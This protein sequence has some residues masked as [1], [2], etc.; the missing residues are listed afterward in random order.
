MILTFPG[1]KGF[2]LIEVLVALMVLT[3]GLLAVAAM[4]AR[5]VRGNAQ[6]VQMT[7]AV[8]CAEDAMEKLL[9]RPYHHADLQD[10]VNPGVIAM[11]CTDHVGTPS[12]AAD[13][14]PTIQGSC[15]VFWNIVDNH[16]VRSCKSIRVLVRR[17]HAAPERPNIVLNSIIMAPD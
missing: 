2:T 17:N 11:N 9:K 3:F 4:Q 7:K 12:C 1:Q 14:G 15:T 13:G 16:P 6:A 10:V 8:A 5:S